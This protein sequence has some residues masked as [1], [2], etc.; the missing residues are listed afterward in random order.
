VRV[1]VVC[2]FF[3][4][5]AEHQTRALRALGAD[6]ALVCRDH[7]HEFSGDETERHDLLERVAGDGVEILEV[8]GRV[9]DVSCLPGVMR[10]WRSLRAWRPDIVHMHDLYDP[11]L[12][13]VTSGRPLVVTVHD[14][15][16][17][18]GAPVLSPSE[19]AVRRH[20][21][22][23][24]VLLVVH[25]ERLQCALERRID[26]TKVAVVP[27]GASPM[28]EPLPVP[29]R[30]SILFFGRLEPYK[31]LDVLVRAVRIVTRARDVELV[32]AGSGPEAAVARGHDGVRLREG[33]VAEADVEA[34]FASASLVVLPYVEASQSGVGLLAVAR[35]IPVVV[36][37]VGA[38][39]ELV[40]VPSYVVPPGDA[41]QLARALLEHI[42]DDLEARR[43]VLRRAESFAWERCAETS[44]RLYGQLAPSAVA[45]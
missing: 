36:S 41:D 24:A 25:G 40:P 31:G 22:R 32:V 17:H 39:P 38:L 34:L 14:V 13:A 15:D 5:Y 9:R 3:L 21:L 45:A 29:G 11:R 2:D 18:L 44:L 33:Y 26:G 19:T 16:R 20:V 28:V 4:K 23:R 7:A 42:D 37:D 6:V 43:R 35:G 8:R 12:L 10:T 1:V 30:R 27:H